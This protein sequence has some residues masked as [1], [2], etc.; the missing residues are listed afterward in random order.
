MVLASPACP[1][2]PPPL[3][4]GALATGGED[5]Q[6]KLWSRSG[7]LR[8][9]L[10]LTDGPIYALAWSPAGDQLV[11][12]YGGQAAVRAVAQGAS[13]PARAWR[14][15]AAGVLCAD[16][17]VGGSGGGGGRIVTGGEDRRYKARPREGR[18]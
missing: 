12:C 13:R 2:P 10:A 17:A 16:W 7:T 4:G 8:A 15:H 14:A 9:T 18:P 5:G 11:Y 1:A 6:L 3:A